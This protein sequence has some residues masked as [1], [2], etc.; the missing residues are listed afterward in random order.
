MIVQGDGI[1]SPP[2]QTLQM[3][4]IVQKLHEWDCHL[5]YHKNVLYFQRKIPCGALV[6]K[7]TCRQL[8]YIEAVLIHRLYRAKTNTN[9]K[10]SYV[11]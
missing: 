2:Q 6:L 11:I 9:K 8:Y 1:T 4:T 3:L 7:D 5:E 10:C